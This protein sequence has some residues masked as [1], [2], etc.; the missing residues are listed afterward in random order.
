MYRFAIAPCGF[1]PPKLQRNRKN[2]FQSTVIKQ[3]Q[4]GRH[5]RI[6]FTSTQICILEKQFKETP[7]LS[8]EQ[9][10]H[11]S[12]LLQ[13]ADIRIKIWFQ[14]RRARE[15]REKNQT[16]ESTNFSSSTTNI[17]NNELDNCLE[18]M[19]LDYVRIKL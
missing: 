3:R 1:S 11:L 15:R 18:G 16:E 4:L 12:E 13:L 19:V 2:T 6:P 9:V 10:L 5:P 14:N 8:S 7:Y 17:S